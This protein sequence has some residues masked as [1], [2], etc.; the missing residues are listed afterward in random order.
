MIYMKRK[1]WYRKMKKGLFTK[2]KNHEM[3]L[4]LISPITI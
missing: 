1:T 4:L 3:L 2:D